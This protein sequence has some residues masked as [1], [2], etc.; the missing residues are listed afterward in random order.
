MTHPVPPLESLGRRI[1]IL[2]PSN[3]G[4][5]TLAV[6]LGQRLGAPVTHLDL[7]RHLPDTDWQERPDAEFAALHDAA[8]AA[9][10]WVVDGNYSQ[11]M[12]QRLAR[13]TGI[14]VLDAPL[15]E[16]YR[17]YFW[18]TLIEREQRAGGLIGNRDSVKWRMIRWIWVSRHAAGRQA[19]LARESGLP[20]VLCR[21]AGDVSALSAAWALRRTN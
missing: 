5:S 14:V 12:P 16:R 17:R 20:F 8:I 1:M 10:N 9:P 18:R 3:S 15:L 2:G 19:Q 13:A 11:L 6:A 21:S 7:M 4:K